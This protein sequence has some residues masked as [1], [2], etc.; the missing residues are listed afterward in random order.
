VIAV[1][2]HSARDPRVLS[3]L[4]ILL[5][6]RHLLLLAPICTA[7]CNLNLGYISI[8]TGSITNYELKCKVNIPR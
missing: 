1:K 4:D 3:G 7:Q 5:I 6:A 2:E 8:S